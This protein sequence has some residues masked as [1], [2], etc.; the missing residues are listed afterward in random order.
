MRELVVTADAQVQDDDEGAGGLEKTARSILLI[1]SVLLGLGLV[2]VYSSTAAAAARAGDFAASAKPLLSQATKLAL[3]IAALAVGLYGSP[4]FFVRHA[5]LLLGLAFVLLAAVCVPGIGAE[6]N[7]AR[8]WI[9]IGSFYL[10]PMEVARVALILWLSVT[11]VRLG[12]RLL[13]LRRGLVPIAAVPAF[14]AVLLLRQPDF[15]SAVFLFGLSILLLV[16]GGARM[17]HFVLIGG[18]VGLACVAYALTSLDHVQFRIQQFLHPETNAQALNSQL[19]LGSGGLAGVG[20]GAGVAK[21]GYLPMISSDFVLA[22]IGEELGFVG[23]S[24]VVMSFLVL[25]LLLARVAAAQQSRVGFLLCSGLTLSIAVQA[26][27]NIAVVTGAA[28]TKGIALP[29]LS[30]GGSALACSCFSIGLMVNLARSPDLDLDAEVLT[31]DRRGLFER[32]L[33]RIGEARKPRSV[34]SRRARSAR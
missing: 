16:L 28:P 14:V 22:G 29:F 25:T 30:A 10:Q 34:L 9:P 2:M 7:K 27:I 8:R 23:T 19:A 15:G 5:R 13:E 21:F 32:L 12:P 20:L 24:L 11:I 3:G 31:R 18:V 17:S 33:D 1:V 26:L 4:R 6:I